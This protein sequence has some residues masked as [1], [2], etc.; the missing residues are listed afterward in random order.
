[1]RNKGVAYRRMLA[2]FA[3]V[4]I[5]PL[6]LVFVFY[7]YS[8][9]VIE[10]QAETSNR[11]FVHT[12]QNTC[13]R[14]LQYYQNVLTQLSMNEQIKVIGEQDLLRPQ[15]QI[16]STQL[17]TSLYEVS[18]SIGLLGNECKD[19]FV[20]FPGVDRVFSCEGRGSMRYDT[21]ANEYYSGGSEE[22]EALRTE[23]STYSRSR[24]LNISTSELDGNAILL[25]C[26]GIRTNGRSSATLGIWLNMKDLVNRIAS[27]EWQDGYDWLIVDE[28]DVVV[29]GS[30]GIYEAGDVFLPEDMS[31][32][33]EYMI[34]TAESGVSTWT[35][36]LLMPSELVQTSAGQIRV[37]FAIS[38]LACV[39]IGCILTRKATVLNY[40]PL[41][42]LLGTFQTRN[43]QSDVRTNEYQFIR[44][45]IKNLVSANTDMESDISRSRKSLAKWSLT[46]MLVKPYEKQ[47]SSKNKGWEEY[48]QNYADG[49][50]QVMMI[51][52]RT[53]SVENNPYGLT[54]DMKLFIIE[55]IF[56]EKMS[57]IVRCAMVEMEGRQVMVL[58][59]EDIACVQSKIQDLLFDLQRII[60]ENFSFSV[61]VSAGD[62]HFG[63]EGIHK[64]YLEAR[65]TEEFIPVLDQDFISYDEIK[66]KTFR[67][68]DYS[69]QAEE[70]IGAAIQ[71]NNAQLAISLIHS[72]IERN[73]SDNQISPNMLKF[74][75]HDIYCTLLKSADEKGCIDRIYML[76]KGF[77]IGQPIA[78]IKSVFSKV[79]ESICD[80]DNTSAEISS[81]R[82]LCMKVL[83]Y[84]KQNYSDPSLNISQTAFHFHV[85]PTSLSAT[86]KNETGKSLLMVINEI[87]IEKAIEYLQQGCSVVETAEKV[88]IP[89]SSSFIR[90]FKK[91]MGMT[92][93]QMKSQMQEKK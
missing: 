37:F 46:N 24:L 23:L 62:A 66:D 29:K 48:A 49:Q 79:V 81:E 57:E 51:K 28:N 43:N 93:G 33:D 9:I 61:A 84:V 70:R 56:V 88:G 4:F 87:R 44:E 7:F 91:H 5:I 60:L 36:V 15:D 68:Y 2:S 17:L 58:H 64:S 14:E 21:Y 42:K 22:R 85:S 26:H 74:L 52:E 76:P 53:D 1:M 67:K 40:E 54:D 77:G 30:Q 59:A 34:Y 71:S 47:F 13:D 75:L 63:L 89:E 12:I 69:L 11:N 38:I 27:V 41:E 16:A 83:E 32:A 10:K 45:Q 19:I 20:Y 18:A 55:N 73:W 90:L 92:P 35:Y 50:N 78:E 65:E 31:L 82:A 72:T 3:M 8:Y 86:Y 80:G 6:C 25:T 39:V